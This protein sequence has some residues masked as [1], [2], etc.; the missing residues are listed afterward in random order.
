MIPAIA[1]DLLLVATLL[2]LVPAAVYFVQVLSARRAAP[3][4]AVAS[5]D[6]RGS[7]A[8]LM[9]AHDEA[10]GIAV[11]IRA[12]LPQLAP[13]D[14]LLV[15][16]DNCSDETAAVASATGAQVT[17]RADPALRGKGYAL[18]HGLRHLGAAPPDV[19]V[20]VDADCV[21]AAGALDL[22]VR[23]C[24]RRQRPTQ[25]LYLMHAPPGA[26][27]RQRIAEFAWA[28]R[29]RV[30]PLGWHR[31]G[32]PCQLMGTGMAFPWPL[33]AT[34]SLASGSIV[35]DMQLG[36]DL[37]LAGVPPCFC[38]AARVTSSFPESREGSLAQRTRWEHGHLAMIVAKGLPLLWRG[39]TRRRLDLVAMALD[40]CVPPLAA[41][42]LLLAALALASAVLAAFGGS[43]TP[44]VLAIAGL[45]S[46]TLATVL[47]WQLAGRAILSL[48]ELLSAPGY[49]IAKIPIYLRLITA[50]QRQWIRTRRDQGDR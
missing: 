43:L 32:L 29:N 37:A 47:A 21:V 45:A 28:V 38:P 17:V 1:E 19:V 20:V 41:L 6:A 50:R 12:L 40:L 5:N 44:L 2:L 23:D 25:A 22:L 33:I 31:L 14:R 39:M 42:V 8:V 30:R 4:A 9:P 27:L 18:D 3:E 13:G 10:A 16:A 36:V 15:V 34:A 24:V 48:S 26:G 46:T 7:I 35:E 49:A 11:S